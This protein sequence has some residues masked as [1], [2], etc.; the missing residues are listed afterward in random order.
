[1]T[2]SE[3]KAQKTTTLIFTTVKP[4]YTSLKMFYSIS[5]SSSSSSSSAKQHFWAIV[6]LRRF[7]HTCLFS[8]ELDHQVFASLDFATIILFYR[9]RS[10]ALHPPPTWSTRSLYLCPPVAQ[11][12][13]QTPDSHFI[14]FYDLQSYGEVF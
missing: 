6:Y 7:C 10:S 4:S 8:C 1:M 13:P 2:P 5:S 9:K 14:T 11:L 12:Y 3:Q